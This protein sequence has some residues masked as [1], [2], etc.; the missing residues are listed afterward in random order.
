[1]RKTSQYRLEGKQ[2]TKAC[3]LKNNIYT[4]LPIYISVAMDIKE[5]LFIWS[6]VTTT[7]DYTCSLLKFNFDYIRKASKLINF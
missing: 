3:F 2:L 5:G 4:N 7:N 1:M 6:I